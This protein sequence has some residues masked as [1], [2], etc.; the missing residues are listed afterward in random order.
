[1]DDETMDMLTVFNELYSISTNSTA[2]D[3]LDKQTTE[4]W[5][6]KIKDRLL[7]PGVRVSH[8]PLNMMMPLKCKCREVST[9]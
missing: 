9:K 2:M 3:T 5:N 6:D 1:M 7:K 8:R 4:Q